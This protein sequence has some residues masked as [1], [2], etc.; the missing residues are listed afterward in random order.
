MTTSGAASDENFVKMKDISVSMMVCPGWS[1]C[2]CHINLTETHNKTTT[3]QSTAKLRLLFCCLRA[4]TYA[5]LNILC[6]DVTQ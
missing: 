2:E 1:V 6:V 3:K 4:K 5:L